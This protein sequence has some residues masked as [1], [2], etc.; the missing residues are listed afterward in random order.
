MA[1]LFKNAGIRAEGS[2]LPAKEFRLYAGQ[3]FDLQEVLKEKGALYIEQAEK[4]L[5]TPY[6]LLRA[7]VFMQ[8]VRNGNRTNYE[9][10]CFAR[11]TM[12]FNFL[13]AELAERKGRFTDRII[14]GVWLL[15]EESTWVLPAHNRS[16]ET[17]EV[18]SLPDRFHTAEEND[19]ITSIDLFSASAG[20]MLAI[21]WKYSADILDPESPTIRKRLLAQ[22]RQRILLPFYH[23]ERDWWMGYR[24]NVLN[25][26]TPWIISNVLTVLAICEEDDEKRVFAVQKSLDILDRFTKTYP[27]DGGCDEG[28]GYWHH[29]GASYFDCLELLWDLSGGKIDLFG[30]PF[31][32]R[33]CEYIMNVSVTKDRYLNFSDA[34]SLLHPSYPVIARMGR[35]TGSP[36][37]CDFAA[38]V[39]DSPR[40][41]AVNDW[42]NAYRAL[43]NLAENVPQTSSFVPAPYTYFPNLQV[44]VTR[45]PDGGM[46]LALK[47][48]HN[49]E[50]HNHNDV[51][52][53]ILF[54]GET[55]LIMDAGVEKYCRDTFDPKKR[56]TLWAMRAKYH[57]I[58]ELNGVEQQP[59]GKFRA[60]TV[61][62]DEDTGRFTLELKNAYPEEAGVISYVRS[63]WLQ[64][65]TATITDKLEMQPDSRAEF[66]YLT[67]SEPTIKDGKI[68]FGSGHVM[69]YDPR[70]TPS[71]DSVDLRGGRIGPQWNTDTMWRIT[72]TAEHIERAE[73]TLTFR[74]A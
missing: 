49:G 47:G 6:P 70:L 27:E 57:N 10:V 40:N 74:R 30:E 72:L 39:N 3:D 41:C 44:A 65:H 7:T 35:R 61:S 37:L 45:E 25:N 52:Q 50:S 28:P 18:V 36:L 58:P 62:Y 55:P 48:G 56:Y 59:G 26:W 8:F 73:Y 15:M 69:E 66:H 9:E 23:Y 42:T 4:D 64:N 32:R 60:K 34:A 43:A 11:R 21:L 63:A 67:V 12:L 16:G 22:L 51:G 2:L 14:D 31:V 71:L 46:Y 13:F 17:N 38:Y 1:E 53:F 5:D 19:D 20:A 54:D 24:G 68:Y 29:A 33:M